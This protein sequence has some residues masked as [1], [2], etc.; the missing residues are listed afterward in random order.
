MTWLLIAVI[1]LSTTDS[2]PTDPVTRS[3]HTSSSFLYYC[4]TNA[5]SPSLIKLK[6]LWECQELSSFVMVSWQGDSLL[7]LMVYIYLIYTHLVILVFQTNNLIGSLSLANEHYLPS[8]KWIMRDQA[9][10]KMA[11]INSFLHVFRAWI[12]RSINRLLMGSFSSVV[13]ITSCLYKT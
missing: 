11:S 7:K 1:A 6:P 2:L 12:A 3:F 4:H 5:F 13:E 10:N 8:S 9:K